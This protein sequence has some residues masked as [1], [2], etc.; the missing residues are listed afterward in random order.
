[1]RVVASCFA[2]PRFAFSLAACSTCRC[3]S[4]SRFVL[5]F[6]ITQAVS[7]CALPL[8]NMHASCNIYLLD[9]FQLMSFCISAEPL[10]SQ[11]H[12]FAV[13]FQVVCCFGCSV[14]CLHKM[15]TYGWLMFGTYVWLLLQ[16]ICC[17]GDN[18][19]PWFRT[20]RLVSSNFMAAKPS[21]KAFLSLPRTKC[22]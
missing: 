18:R 15:A 6:C 13:L 17:Q 22:T 8:A 9:L 1:M 16:N 4:A 7:A 11:F 20:F 12:G 21:S 19:R 10:C 2:G 14:T 5:E 3:S